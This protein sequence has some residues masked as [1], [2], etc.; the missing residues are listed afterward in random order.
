MANASA[1]MPKVVI[2]ADNM[3]DLM[4]N[5]NR[6]GQD[7]SGKKV[8]A[9][10][11]TIITKTEPKMVAG[12][13]FKDGEVLKVSRVQMNL[14]CNY[15]KI[16]NAQRAREGL[17]TDFKP[18]PRK[19]GKRIPDTPFIVHAPKG[20]TEPKLYLDGKVEKS[21]EH[22]YEDANGN[23][24]DA[25]KVEPWLRPKGK[26]RQGVKDERYWR[27]YEMKNILGFVFDGKVWVVSDNLRLLKDLAAVRTS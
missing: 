9:R 25:S 23:E 8:G 19:W 10:F 4:A 18:E 13:P 15:A 14:G 2:T 26:S 22:W 12:H 24:I 6:E 1:T 7:P 27:T 5:I 16:V 3:T 21:V 11:I 20:E 17:P